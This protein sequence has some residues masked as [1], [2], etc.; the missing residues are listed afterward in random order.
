MNLPPVV[1]VDGS[2]PSR[3]AVGRA[4]DEAAQRLVTPRSVYEAVAA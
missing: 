3:R 1:G 2:E 4:A